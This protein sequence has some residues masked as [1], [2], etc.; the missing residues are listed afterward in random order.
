MLKICLTAHITKGFEMENTMIGIVLGSSVVSSVVSALFS[1]ITNRKNN[2]LTHI[3]IEREKWREKIRR[4][5]ED[6]EETQFQGKKEKNINQYLVQ[7]EVNINPYGKRIEDDFARDSHIWAEIENIRQVKDEKEFKKHK[8]LL[9]YYLS[10]MLK[11]D[12]ERSKREVKGYSSTLFEL[13]VILFLNC[14]IGAYYAYK[15]GNRYIDTLVCVI[16]V[17]VIIYFLLRYFQQLGEGRI[18]SNNR[19]RKLYYFE[20]FASYI[21]MILISS[22][23]SF[24]LL[25][26]LKTFYSEFAFVNLW[27]VMMCGG[28]CLYIC[29]TWI[30]RGIKRTFLAEAV[31]DAR[32]KILDYNKQKIEQY[33]A[34]VSELYNYISENSQNIKGVKPSI[35]SLNKIIKEYKV[36]LIDRKNILSREGMNAERNAEYNEI[37]NKIEYLD[38]MQDK[39]LQYSSEGIINKI[40]RWVKNIFVYETFKKIMIKMKTIIWNEPG[41]T[42]FN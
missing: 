2:T 28:E 7:L 42:P 31:F 35:N 22:I 1:H 40:L 34:T 12:W 23:I 39:L 36:E 41:K 20:V 29:F 32:Q 33:D 5:S 15:L 24:F 6:I 13:L 14:G 10:L 38:K 27:A 30:K 26:F 9:I 4:I 25:V 8:E 19:V 17:S 16:A 21:V 37:Q 18:V 11:E 3:T